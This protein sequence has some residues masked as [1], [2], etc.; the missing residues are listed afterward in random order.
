MQLGPDRGERFR[1]DR[2]RGHASFERLDLRG[3]L[4][5]V[6]ALAGELL[7]PLGEG[8]ERLRRL[9]V[10]RRRELGLEP[11]LDRLE[12]RGRCLVQLVADSDEVTG[13]TVDPRIGLGRHRGELRPRALECRRQILVGDELCKPAFDRRHVLRER[14]VRPRGDV[15]RQQLQP[16]VDRPERRL[17]DALGRER[18]I[19]P[20]RER[21]DLA[22][23]G[24]DCRLLVQ[25]R[26]EPLQSRV[27][28]GIAR[29]PSY[30]LG[31]GGAQLVE[32][33]QRAVQA[34]QRTVD[35]VERGLVGERLEP[36]RELVRLAAGVV[37]HER[38]VGELVDEPPQLV[39]PCCEG[40]IDRRVGLM[41][42]QLGDRRL[43]PGEVHRQSRHARLKHPERFL[44]AA[45]HALE[46]VDQRCDRRLEPLGAGDRRLDALARAR[47]GGRRAGSRCRSA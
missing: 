30:E 24:C 47:P 35:L 39:D 21:L 5:L 28:L 2:V 13:E 19:E 8:G 11:R 26:L 33:G 22:G 45:R 37:V 10:G 9:R 23:V 20:A 3:E 31:D 34:L 46:A 44:D 7:D 36:C 29:R 14:R 38:P 25:P 41:R 4:F 42:A 17:E 12:P 27:E 6:V 18:G 1:G 32:V 15:P 16:F 43:D 40:G